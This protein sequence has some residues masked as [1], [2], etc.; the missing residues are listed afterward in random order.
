M[1]IDLA[2]IRGASP[3]SA[4]D[5]EHARADFEVA[6]GRLL[7]TRTEANFQEWRDQLDWTARKNAM[8]ERGELLPS[9]KTDADRKKVN[10]ESG[11]SPRK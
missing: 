11:R 3:A 8:W 10:A 7:T 6:W 1:G 5:F 9:Q 2:S 4:V